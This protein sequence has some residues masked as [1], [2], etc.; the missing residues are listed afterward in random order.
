[1]VGTVGV[2]KRFYALNLILDA[3]EL[4]T[5]LK[6]CID[7][8][9]IYRLVSYGIDLSHD[10]RRVLVSI[11]HPSSQVCNGSLWQGFS[12]KLQTFKGV[13]YSATVTR[14]VRVRWGIAQTYLGCEQR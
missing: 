5:V 13:N 7:I 6:V 11:R 1:M 12:C 4:L 14:F 8:F 9:V 10:R 2:I 3:A